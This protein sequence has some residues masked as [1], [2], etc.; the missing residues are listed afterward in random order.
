MTHSDTFLLRMERCLW[1]YYSVPHRVDKVHAENQ[2]V[3]AHI[4]E[5]ALDLLDAEVLCNQ[6]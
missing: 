4:F 6:Q 3:I 2:N 5:K 1:A